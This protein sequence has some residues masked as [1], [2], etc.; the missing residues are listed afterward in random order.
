[1]GSS[2]INIASESLTLPLNLRQALTSFRLPDRARTLWADS[3]CI[4]QNDQR[5]RN[6]QVMLMQAIYTQA[7][8]VLVWLGDETART[9][10]VFSLFRDLGRLWVTCKGPQGRSN[11]FIF[12]SSEQL[13]ILYH[14]EHLSWATPRGDAKPSGFSEA[15]LTR[16][17]AAFHLQDIALWT[18]ADE[19]FLNSYFE[20]A[21]ILQEIA[22]GKS[23]FVHCGK[24]HLSWDVMTT[25]QKGSVLLGKLM[26]ITFSKTSSSIGA[27]QS[28]ICA[29]SARC[30][31]QH[32]SERKNLEQ[33]LG[34]FLASKSSNPRD[35]I[36]AAVGLVKTGYGSSIIPNYDKSVETVFWEAATLMVRETGHIKYLAFRASRNRK[37]LKHSPSWVPDWSAA[38]PASAL[39]DWSWILANC[40]DGW[41]RIRGPILSIDGH[42]LDVVEFVARSKCLDDLLLII[43]RLSE[44]FTKQG[45]GLFSPYVSYE[46]HDALIS[47]DRRAVDSD[48][49]IHMYNLAELFAFFCRTID[50]PPEIVQ[51]MQRFGKLRKHP[52]NHSTLNIE[53]LYLT[54]VARLDANRAPRVSAGLP[55]FLATITFQTMMKSHDG[56]HFESFGYPKRYSDWIEL[57]AWLLI[58]QKS[59]PFKTLIDL[60]SE[61]WRSLDREETFFVTTKGHFG[62]APDGHVEM[63]HAIAILG[64]GGTPYVL[65]KHSG[66]Y[67]IVSHCYV[68]GLMQMKSLK[69]GMSIERLEIH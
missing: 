51:I 50:L 43:G 8:R 55:L 14:P 13:D 39:L 62:R 23:V 3:L 56:G 44:K 40:F 18:E 32:P 61:H 24:Q 10:D 33:V 60:C 45:R 7:D 11:P 21:W 2:T 26:D 53:A 38:V 31:Y 34:I 12:E 17:S 49:L 65:E 58:G 63:G 30:Y 54:L 66:Y 27:A 16:G 28:L 68:E 25:A 41:P 36:Y 5:E 29:N 37:T 4:N 69:P 6:Q 42:V 48:Y 57:A 20:R 64:G 19:L 67:E 46:D 9:K 15:G 35:M 47:L 52:H 1:M 22:V 59:A